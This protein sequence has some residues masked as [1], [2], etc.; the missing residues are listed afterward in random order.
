[1]PTANRRLALSDLGGISA[2][3]S[4]GSGGSVVATTSDLIVSYGG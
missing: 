3:G 4:S 1:M 2:T